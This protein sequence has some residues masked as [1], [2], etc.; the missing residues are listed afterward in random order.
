MIRVIFVDDNIG[1]ANRILGALKT[2]EFEKFIEVVWVGSADAARVRLTSEFDLLILDVCIPK[3]NDGTA[4]AKIGLKLLNDVCDMDS[5]YVRPS[6]IIGLTANTNDIG[7]YQAEF[8]KRVSVVLDGDSSSIG[9]LDTLLDN[10]SSLIQSERKSRA[11]TENK[12]LITVHGIRTF[13][14]WQRSLKDSMQSYTNDFEFFEFKYGFFDLF[15]FSIPFFRKRKIKEISLRLRS[16]LESDYS[17]D[18]YIVA[19]SFGTFIASEALKGYD[20]KVVN[21]V[22]LCGSPI[23]HKTDIDHIVSSSK[24]TVNE[25]GGS[26]FILISARILLLGLGDAGRV[27]F[28]RDHSPQFK[29]RFFDGGHSLYFEKYRGS[30]FFSKYW[31]P[32]LCADSAIEDVDHRKNY[33]F[34]DIIEAF[35]RVCGEAKSV[36]YV[37]LFMIFVFNFL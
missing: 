23:S 31:I 1:R 29:N 17:G 18:T 28:S 19:H 37:F 33:V 34:Q 21:Q 15:S 7:S 5:R 30:D 27:G 24:F 4:S 3:K 8:S 9:W 25:C 6:L 16:L 20:G 13:G 10:V 11:A 32:S 22:I 35:V 12:R 14:S 36:I 26:D 2:S